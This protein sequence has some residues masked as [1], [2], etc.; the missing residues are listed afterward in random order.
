MLQSSLQTFDP[1]V[2]LSDIITL[3]NETKEDSDYIT[4][5]HITLF[6][7]EDWVEWTVFTVAFFALLIFDNLV[8]HRGHETLSFVRA[9]LYTIFFLCCAGAFNV[10]VYYS[11]GEEAAFIWATG[12]LLEWMLSVDNLF[13]FHLVFQLYA[14]PHNQRH[15]PLFYGIVGAILFRML[16]FI[17]EETLF[18]S[19]WWMHIV[20][21]LFLI[22]TGFRSAWDDEED[23]DPTQNGMVIWLSDHI[24]LVKYYDPDGKFFVD[25]YSPPEPSCASDI[26]AHERECKKNGVKPQ[27]KATM[28][29]VVVLCLEVTDVIFAV[30]SVSAIVAQ[31]PD[32][33]LAYT[34][35]VFA[36]LGLRA[37]YFVID[38]LIAM[39]SLLKYGVA[40]ILVFI[41]MKLLLHSK[42][43][44]ST[45]AVFGILL[46]TIA[47]SM[48]GS[49]A[50]DKWNKSKESAE[51]T[52]T[53][54]RKNSMDGG[55]DGS[56]PGGDKDKPDAL[57]SILSPAGSAQP[58]SS[59]R[60]RQ[61]SKDSTPATMVCHS[62]QTSRQNSP[63]GKPILPAFKM[64]P[65]VKTPRGEGKAEEAK[66]EASTKEEEAKKEANTKEE[67][68]KKEANTKAEVA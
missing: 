5:K 31:V 27:K 2:H 39:F 14:C 44:F 66:K 58:N 28:L 35:C 18:H 32:L 62:T 10:Y 19:F 21:G 46:G 20:F 48:F 7:E 33:F 42:V 55:E 67:E 47:G 22:Y 53:G 12:Y 56:R 3:K 45:G 59:R 30:D 13:V 6:K 40:L 63:L 54:S 65:R 4:D 9:S 1:K 61:T 23:N 37:T 38:D 41:G 16:F 15:K 64:T 17:V 11:M 8:L 43:H 25:D 34:A 60:G 50:L 51:G 36:M 57:K 49:L 52:P 68:A 26:L 24:P 29:F